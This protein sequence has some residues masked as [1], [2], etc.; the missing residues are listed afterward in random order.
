VEE[1]QTLGKPSEHMSQVQK[2]GM[3][4]KVTIR[5]GPTGRMFV[6]DG[7]L[8]RFKTLSQTLQASC[9]CSASWDLAKSIV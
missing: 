5:H 2:G 6:R 3:T 7:K 1:K 8:F 9:V 4:S